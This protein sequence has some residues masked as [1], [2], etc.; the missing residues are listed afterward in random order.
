MYLWKIDHLR[1]IAP[2]LQSALGLFCAFQRS[3]DEAESGNAYDDAQY[4][5]RIES[6]RRVGWVL[7]ES[8]I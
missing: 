1:I 7:T 4:L 5:K 8:D 2:T 6:V 3:A